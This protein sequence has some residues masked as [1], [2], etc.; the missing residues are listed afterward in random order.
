[1]LLVEPGLVLGVQRIRVFWSGGAMRKRNKVL[2]LIALVT[3]AVGMRSL[4][5]SDESPQ[6]GG[7]SLK[8]WF[9]A[10]RHTV[11][12]NPTAAAGIAAALKGMGT[13]EMRY[14][15][16]EAFNTRR[17]SVAYQYF[18]EV[19]NYFP[20]TL[21]LPRLLSQEESRWAAAE[22]ICS[23][24]PVGSVVLPELIDYARG[25][26][27]LWRSRALQ[28]L[29]YTGD[30]NEQVARCLLQNLDDPSRDIQGRAAQS[31]IL[32]G[33]A[34]SGVVPGL[35]ARL[36]ATNPNQPNS[37]AFLLLSVLESY[38][39][40]AGAAIPSLLTWLER[41]DPN[42]ANDSAYERGLTTL[43]KIGP[44]D[45]RTWS[46]LEHRFEAKTNWDFQTYA[47]SVRALAK[48]GRD[49]PKTLESLRYPLDATTDWFQRCLTAS[50]LLSI[51]A[52]QIEAWRFLTNAL[53][54]E[55]DPSRR[56]ILSNI[57]E[58]PDFPAS[59]STR[60]H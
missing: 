33:A 31:L 44:T 35:S 12:D 36:L 9:R 52:H 54:T 1:V 28:I 4:V 3:L 39:D 27:L 2:V 57:F 42:Q 48:L 14:L 19:E 50:V 15:L 17:D 13:N 56:A 26:N 43:L 40:K 38:G 60:A 25:T 32:F 29:G 10:Y 16:V 20:R 21:R 6:Y 30:N 49:D 22:L 34:D 5:T 51:N 24:R 45:P 47:R 8:A 37:Q 59:Q 41:Q 46:L 58:R 7:R 55:S 53:A 18:E 11:L 23:T